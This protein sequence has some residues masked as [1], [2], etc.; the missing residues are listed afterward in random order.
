MNDKNI[1]VLIGTSSIVFLLLVSI[2]LSNLGTFDKEYVYVNTTI[3][4]KYHY[5]ESYLAGRSI[6]IS[7]VYV[8]EVERNNAT[9][10]VKVS[11]DVYLQLDIGDDYLYKYYI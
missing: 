9:R 3:T 8:F 11:R 7:E 2:G 4:D 6:V 1:I 10:K 5:T